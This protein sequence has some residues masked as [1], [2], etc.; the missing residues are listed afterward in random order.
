[1]ALQNGISHICNCELKTVTTQYK[2]AQQYSD[3]IMLE[4]DIKIRKVGRNEV[5]TWD[6]RCCDRDLL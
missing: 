2:D 4:I 5:R 6:P 1:M 3:I